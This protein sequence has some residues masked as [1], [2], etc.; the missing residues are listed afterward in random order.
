ME[1]YLYLSLKQHKISVKEETG[2]N[3]IYMYIN[4]TT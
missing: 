1:V 2:I 3:P 4:P